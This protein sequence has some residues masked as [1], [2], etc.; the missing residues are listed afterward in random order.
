MV[1]GRIVGWMFL[2]AALLAASTEIALS[3]R[4]GGF[5]SLPLGQFWADLHLT[6]LENLES[7]LRGALPWAWDPGM[8]TALEMP[9]WPLL[10]ACAAVLLYL[11]RST[12]QAPTRAPVIGANARPRA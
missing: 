4:A 1:V 5:T 9:A 3:V 8:T 10:L 2:A 6:S 7:W 12:P 11:F